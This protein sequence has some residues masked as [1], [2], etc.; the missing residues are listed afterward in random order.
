MKK[1]T[2]IDGIELD[3]S[4]YISTEFDIDDYLA[5]KSVAID[6]STVMF[7]QPKGS[8]TREV[9]VYSKSNGWQEEAT[10]DLL[11][12]SIDTDVV[13]VTYDDATTDNFYY[14]HSKVPISFD[15]L[16]AGSL[17]YNVTINLIR[18]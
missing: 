8:M 1:V 12:A 4:M 5:S 3:H 18:G 11:T 17:W 15:P 10:K 2:H 9:E 7:V 16:Y 14:D 13:V 6:G